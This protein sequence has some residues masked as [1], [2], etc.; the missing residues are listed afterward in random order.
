MASFLLGIL[1]P[2][3]PINK[4]F[5]P[6]AP[7][8]MEVDI[9]PEFSQKRLLNSLRNITYKWQHNDTILSNQ[10]LNNALVIAPTSDT[11]AGIYKVK[12]ASFGFSNH[13]TNEVCAV[14]VLEYLRS[15]AIFQ[16]VE[17]YAYNSKI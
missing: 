17:F 9:L 10:V 6:P 8:Q 11:D 16:G 12:I 14:I 13:A 1:R 3:E 2:I 4:V 7:L 5:T 15:Y